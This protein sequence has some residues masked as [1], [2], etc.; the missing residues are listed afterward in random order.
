MKP[1]YLM[2][3]GGI[4][5]TVMMYELWLAGALEGVFFCNYHQASMEHCLSLVTH[6]ATQLGV[7]VKPLTVDAPL[8]HNGDALGVYTPGFRPRTRRMPPDVKKGTKEEREFMFREWSWVDGRN[9]LF[10]T[11][12]AIKVRQLGFDALYTAFQ[13]N[14]DYWDVPA[15]KRYRY[16]TGPEF[17]SAMNALYRSGA[18][19]EPVTLYA[20]YLDKK[21]NKES[22]VRRG[23]KLS[24]DL[25]M[26]HSCEFY[27]ACER[28]NQ[29]QIRAEVFDT[30][31]G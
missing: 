5:S 3:S 8:T 16:D 7:R 21:L 20:P 29:C 30:V 10:F 19:I 17:V 6:H 28:C 14:D 24:V 2:A 12:A 27:P 25:S 22:I 4:D 26:T 31:Y 9:A 15:A 1:G 23:A 18:F 11:K 13:F